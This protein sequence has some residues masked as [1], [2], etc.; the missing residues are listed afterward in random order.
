MCYRYTSE[1]QEYFNFLALNSTPVSVSQCFLG[2]IIGQV[3]E[4]K[5]KKF[6]PMLYCCIV[7]GT[8]FLSPMH[9]YK[10]ACVLSM[11]IL[12]LDS[13]TAICYLVS[14]ILILKICSLDACQLTGM[15]RK[16]KSFYAILLTFRLQ[17]QQRRYEYYI[18]NCGFEVL[19]SA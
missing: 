9:T 1:V 13:K 7:L 14:D 12:T 11:F 3:D 6:S 5:V 2:I 10:Y 18:N 19:N 8:S 17:W 4:F 16:E 15:L